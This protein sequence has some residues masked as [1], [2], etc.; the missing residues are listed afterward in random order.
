MAQPRTATPP[1]EFDTYQLVILRRPAQPP[2]YDDDTT[3][4]LFS[5][6]LGHLAEM[7]DAGHL[8]AAGPLSDQPDDGLRGIC[9]FRT[10][11][12][13]KA[14]ELAVQDPAV[15]AGLFVV[16]VMTW[17]TPKGEIPFGG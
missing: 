12:V 11:S 2:E 3:N 8:L 15:Q 13:E 4:L 1:A 16:D 5:Q 6:H 17:R 10:G 14:R 9:L 7:R